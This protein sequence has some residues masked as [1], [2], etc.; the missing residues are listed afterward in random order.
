M[1]VRPM[2]M[3]DYDA[4]LTLMRGASGVAV[5]AADA[6]QAIIEGQQTQPFSHVPPPERGGGNRYRP[7]PGLH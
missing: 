5:R 3:A 2:T 7:G 4:V 1:N 6:P